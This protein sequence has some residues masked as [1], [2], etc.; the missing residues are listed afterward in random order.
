MIPQNGSLRLVIRLIE[1]RDIEEARVLHNEDGTLAKLTDIGHV[2]EAQQEGW[3][4]SV[5]TSRTSRRYVARLR[6]DDS[7]VGVFR[8]DHIDLW[9]R[10]AMVGADVVAHMRRQGF[11]RE[12][13]EYVLDYLFKHCGLHRV[14]LVT[15][16]NNTAAIAL[17]TKLGFVEEGREREAIFRDG[18]FQ[19][20]VAM[21]LLGR[22]WRLIGGNP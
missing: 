12:M 14:G 21:G 8:V 2:S 20:L 16:A 13:F 3:F 22:E 15:L 19:N 17:Y 6:T 10:N 7:F 11:A 1:R 9:N 5:S 4:Q 18:R